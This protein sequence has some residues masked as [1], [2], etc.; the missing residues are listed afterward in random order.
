MSKYA[1]VTDMFSVILKMDF[2]VMVIV[3]ARLSLLR[4]YRATHLL[5]K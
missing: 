3:V 1:G 2:D 5:R 4:K